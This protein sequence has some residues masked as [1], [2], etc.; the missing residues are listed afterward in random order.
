MTDDKITRIMTIGPVSRFH[1][2]TKGYEI[3]ICANCNKDARTLSREARLSCGAIL[4]IP[5][6][7]DCIDLQTE[8][9]VD[10]RKHVHVGDAVHLTRYRFPLDEHSAQWMRNDIS[11]W[12]REQVR[13]EFVQY[14]GI[15]TE[16]SI[17]AATMNVRFC[18]CDI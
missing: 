17:P 5:L 12:M 6:C 9:L 2:F 8:K 18:N 13:P 11:K 4:D 16:V 14:H 15:I 1:S 3:G 10:R 7:K